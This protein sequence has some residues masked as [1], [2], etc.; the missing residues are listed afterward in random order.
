[1][2]LLIDQTVT[3]HTSRHNRV[4]VDTHQGR[5]ALFLERY[6]YREFVNPAQMSHVIQDMVITAIPMDSETS[7]KLVFT[8]PHNFS[9]SQT[10]YNLWTKTSE[11][12]KLPA[13]LSA[14]FKKNENKIYY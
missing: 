7:D 1:M 11:V 2:S 10:F 14:S 4:F 3:N 9:E 13:N 8:H 6:D 12:E 5:R